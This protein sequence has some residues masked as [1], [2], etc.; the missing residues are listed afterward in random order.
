MHC[1][2]NTVACRKHKGL[3]GWLCT[4]LEGSVGK[5]DCAVKQ[6]VNIIERRSTDVY[7]V[8]VTSHVVLCK[9]ELTFYLFLLT[10]L[11]LCVHTHMCASVCRC[12]C[13]CMCAHVCLA[14]RESVCARHTERV[15]ERVCVCVNMCV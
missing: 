1:D 9:A 10:G 2:S 15:R 4:K 7:D 14:V 12:V 8:A 6:L 3:A 13:V 11:I 5:L